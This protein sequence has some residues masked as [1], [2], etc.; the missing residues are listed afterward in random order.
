M[1]SSDLTTASEPG[2]AYTKLGR[3]LAD[4]RQRRRQTGPPGVC[5]D[6]W[7]QRIANV[8]PGEQ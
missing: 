7:A 6:W 2:K 4:Q 5:E 3:R 8:R 1:E